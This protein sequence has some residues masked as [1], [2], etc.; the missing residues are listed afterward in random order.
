L[1]SQ[2]EGGGAYKN[3]VIDTSTW[4]VSSS[5]LSNSP[6]ITSVG[7]GWYRISITELS[8]AAGT[9]IFHYWNNP[10]GT[11]SIYFWGA[12]L[13]PGSTATDYVRT[14]DVVGKAYRWYE[15]TEGTVWLDMPD[16]ALSDN[17]RMVYF[18]NTSLSSSLIDMFYNKTPNRI[19][20]YKTSDAS[21]I[22]IGTQSIPDKISLAYK[23]NDYN[24][25]LDGVTGGADTSTG[26]LATSDLMS[27][28]QH[29]APGG[30]L[31]GHIKRLAYWPTRQPD[32]T[33]QVITQ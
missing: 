17:S 15:P 8:P 32:A 27:I 28:G 14:V 33:L 16:F 9:R 3:F 11:G 22:G 29:G 21:Q 25:S 20:Y 23:F 2:I 19:D 18:G 26:N 30:Y 6:V 10:T 31:N 5:T 13:E 1:Y 4:T 24:G 7:N 12:Q